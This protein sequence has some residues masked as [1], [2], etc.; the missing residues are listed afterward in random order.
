MEGAN[1]KRKSNLTDDQRKCLYL[2]LLKRS[3]DGKVSRAI[4][5][6]VCAMFNVHQSTGWRIFQRGNERPPGG[7]PPDVN[8]RLKGNNGR[9]RQYTVKE[10]EERIKA[11]P[12]HLRQTYRALSSATGLSKNLLWRYIQSKWISRRSSWTRP[13][14][15][16]EHKA[17]RLAFCQSQYDNEGNINEMYS[18]VHIDEKWFYMTKLCRKFYLWCDEEVPPRPLQSK[19]HITKVMFLVA[20]A[21]PRCGW[22]GKIGCWALVEES[23][24]L[25]SSVNRPA[26]ARVIKTL[27]VTREI[28]REYLIK[29][30]IPAIK[31]KWVWPA[32]VQVGEIVIQ[33]DNARPHVLENDVAVIR[34]G[35]SGGWSIVVRNQPAKSPDLNVL[36]LGFFNSIQALQQ[37]MVCSSIESLIS[38]VK[39]AFA[40][41]PGSTLEST[42]GTLQRVIA[43]IVDAAG[44]N[45]YKVPRSLNFQ[46]DILA[47]DM[48]NLRLEEEDRLE[49]LTQMMDA[50]VVDVE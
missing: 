41:L 37:Q 35:Q 50:L 30:V 25:R 21:R 47:L 3:T 13:A 6:D 32:G 14:V 17:A 39:T 18:M 26:G 27:T 42:F 15:T 16:P 19:A 11:V 10:I 45:R 7:G 36:D 33:Q 8:A 2:E 4:M 43:A 29:S 31:E 44:D 24:A 46:A 22:D 23:K 12:L 34:A 28:Y 49:E 38:A 48:M 1:T 5:N 20:V 40:E 9:R